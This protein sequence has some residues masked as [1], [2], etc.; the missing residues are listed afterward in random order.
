LNARLLSYERRTGHHVLVWIGPTT[1]NTPVEDFTVRAFRAWRVGRKGMDDGLVLF[2]FTEDRK[3]RIEVGY[4]LEAQVPD[5]VASRVIREIVLPRVEAGDHDGA[6]EAGVEALLAAIGGAPAAGAGQ[7]N[8]ARQSRRGSRPLSPLESIALGIV[9]LLVLLFVVTH[10]SLAFFFLANI[11]SERGGGGW[12]SDDSDRY[13][14][15]GGRSGG[16]GATGSW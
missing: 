6:V 10:P 2:L 16:G 9:G 7:Q 1:G 4:G 13:S 3:A 5:A 15:G 8:P 12:E 11:L 14:G